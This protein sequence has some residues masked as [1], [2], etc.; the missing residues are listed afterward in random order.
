MID[1]TLSREERRALVEGVDE[2]APLV[3][4]LVATLLAHQKHLEGRRAAPVQGGEAW[5][6]MGR[7]QQLQG[8]SAG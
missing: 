7:W 2:D 3:A 6:L 1:V 5:G 8:N 4:A